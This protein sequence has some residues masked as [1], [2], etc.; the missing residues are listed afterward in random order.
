M[1]HSDDLML[2]D[3]FYGEGCEQNSVNVPHCIFAQFQVTCFALCKALCWS[4][5]YFHCFTLYIID[6]VH[7]LS[8][9]YIY[10][11]ST[12]K[13]SI[14]VENRLLYVCRLYVGS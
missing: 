2:V 10:R 8:L 6:T 4:L 3:G 9:L 13:L 1:N 11:S 14:I 12:E 7:P 5:L